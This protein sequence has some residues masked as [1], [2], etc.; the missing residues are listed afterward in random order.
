MVI[1]RGW[2]LVTSYF[3]PDTQQNIQETGGDRNEKKISLYLPNIYSLGSQEIQPVGLQSRDIYIDMSH[4]T[5]SQCSVTVSQCHNMS[6]CHNETM[7]KCYNVTES[8]LVINT[9]D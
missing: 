1:Q 6:Q 4:V 9:G 7:T 2:L 5:V 8:D 3:I